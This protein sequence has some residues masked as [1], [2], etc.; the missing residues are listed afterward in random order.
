[1]RPSNEQWC[2]PMP[3]MLL[4]CLRVSIV[5]TT[6]L[7][8]TAGTHMHWTTST[9]PAARRIAPMSHHQHTVCTTPAPA[10]CD[11]Q[12][13]TPRGMADC[14]QALRVACRLALP[15]GAIAADGRQT[16]HTAPGP[17]A[18][19]DRLLDH[20]PELTGCLITCAC[21][22][23]DVG[24]SLQLLRPLLPVPTGSRMHV[25]RLTT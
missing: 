16:D 21:Y 14:L 23:G 18:L 4:R 8:C 2:L 19:D 25:V 15:A 11:A 10:Q 24:Q 12:P 3:Q 1:M 22:P 13:A 17:R 9:L 5:L 7:M 20:T 6:V